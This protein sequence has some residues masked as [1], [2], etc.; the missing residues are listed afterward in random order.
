MRKRAWLA[1]GL[2]GVLVLLLAGCGQRIT[3]EEIVTHMQDTVASTQDAHAV[4]H[5]SVNAQGIEISATA[6]I[7]E[8]LPN[9]LRAEVLET[10]RAEFDGTVLVSDGQQA[11]YYNPAKNTVLVGPMDEIET[12]L[13]Q[14]MI[15]EM[16][17]MIQAVLDASEVELAGE[18]VLAGYEAYK[19]V[20]TPK[21]DEEGPGA[22]LFP[23]NGTATLWV[24]KEQW[25]VLKATYEAGSFGQGSLEVE[26]FELNPGLPDSLFV[27]DVPEGATVI[28]V[29]SQEPVPLTLEEARAQA[30]FPLLV[31]AYVPEGVTL[32]EVFR[33]GGSMILRYDHSPEI[34]FTLVQGPELTGPPPLGE[35][36]QLTVRGQ[37]ATVV[38][39]EAG[40]NT[41]LYWTED[42]VTITIAGHLPLAE[43][44]QVAESLQ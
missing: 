13:P 6:E 37:E 30:E 20:L 10:S 11:W 14:Q 19:L 5:A 23:G 1:L 4:V 3:A 9:S 17:D 41:F 32:V 15:G 22:T 25:I 12:P 44:I 7:W 18:E 36:Q 26:S 40:G 29:E 2:V 8:K 33:V 28:D 16:Q 34:A 38:Q 24:D 31:P 35:S 21:E 39:D 43:A 42:G 27:F